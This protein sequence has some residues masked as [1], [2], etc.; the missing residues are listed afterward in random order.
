M[1]AKLR[2][3]KLEEEVY[4]G[5]F[6][7]RTLSFMTPHSYM[8]EKNNQLERLH[9]EKNKLEEKH[10]TWCCCVQKEKHRDEVEKKNEELEKAKRNMEDI[11]DRVSL[12]DYGVAAPENGK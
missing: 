11:L 9:N 12:V 2:K 4:T 8:V 1:E 6:L 7:E 10:R 5:V 3:L